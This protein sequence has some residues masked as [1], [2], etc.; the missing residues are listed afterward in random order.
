MRIDLFENFKNQFGVLSHFESCFQ[1]AL[2]AKKVQSRNFCILDGEGAWIEACSGDFPDWT[3]GFNVMPGISKRFEEHGIHHIAL[4]VDTTPY[5]PEL[6]SSPNSVAACVDEDSAQFF[7]L[8][9][10]KKSLFL[11]HAIEKEALKVAIEEDRPYDVVFAGSFIDADAEVAMWKERF[12]R[13]L[14]TALEQIVEDA[15]RS[16][17]SYMLLSIELFQANPVLLQDLKTANISLFDAMISVDRAL[18]GLERKALLGSLQGVHLHIFGPEKDK[19]AWQKIVKTECTYHGPQTFEEM[20]AVFQKSRVVVNSVPMFK[21]AVHERVL[22]A[23][24]GGASVIT[25]KNSYMQETLPEGK[26]V[27]YFEGGD[28]KSA[29]E[30][31]GDMLKD[32]KKRLEA[33]EKARNAIRQHHTWDNRVETLLNYLK[34]EVQE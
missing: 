28:Y 26:G 32:E 19:E 31:I 3:A 27:G 1:D 4:L 22:Y 10:H 9:G 13:P 17:K 12:S 33:V 24:A 6:L 15:L 21:R 5:S 23:L 2:R 14:R 20:R 8:L 7:E 18:R 25:N 16:D 29:G 34:R 11:P 30:K